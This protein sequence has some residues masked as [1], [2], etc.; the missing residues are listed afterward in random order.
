V[1]ACIKF[2]Q[3]CE[4]RNLPAGEARDKALVA[5]YKKHRL[6]YGAYVPDPLLLFSINRWFD[7]SATPS[8]KKTSRKKTQ[9]AAENPAPLSLPPTHDMQVTVNYTVVGQQEKPKRKKPTD[10]LKEMTYKEL[11]KQLNYCVEKEYYEKAAIIKQE[12]D[13]RTGQ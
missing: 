3:L 2:K 7:E 6:S 4:I 11:E 1:K 10:K 12:M 8:S 5:F 9:A 13:R